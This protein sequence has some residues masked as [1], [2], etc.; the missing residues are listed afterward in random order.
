MFSFYPYQEKGIHRCRVAIAKGIRRLIIHAPTGAGKTVIASGIIQSAQSKNRNVLFV[1]HRKELIDQASKKLDAFQ[2]QHGVIMSNHWRRRYHDPV[3]V[4]SIHTWRSWVKRAET[5]PLPAAFQPYLDMDSVEIDWPSI[6]HVWRQT[7]FVKTF[8]PHLIFIDECHL[9]IAPSYV[10]LVS[11]FPKAVLLGM[12]ATPERAD[13]LP[14][15]EL[16]DGIV[17]ISTPAK[18]IDQGYLV[19]P[20]HYAPV[21]PDLTKVGIKNNDYDPD[22]LAEKF[23]RPD[24]IGDMV[25]EW[26][27]RAKGR[28]TIAFAI[29][30][31]HSRNICEQFESRGIRA[32][33]L[34][35]ESTKHEREHGLAML[36]SGEV[37]VI[38]NVGIFTEGT[39]LPYVSCIILAVAT[40]SL[41]RYL[42]QG[43]RGMRTF[44]DAHGVQKKDCIILDHSGCYHAH[45]PLDADRKWSLD[46]KKKKRKTPAKPKPKVC[47]SCKAIFNGSICPACGWSSEA[48]TFTLTVDATQEL[49]E[50]SPSEI[51]LKL[52]KEEDA[53][54]TIEELLELA[55]QRGYKEA[56]AY[57]RFEARQRKFQAM[58]YGVTQNMPLASGS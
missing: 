49:N 46:G 22:E 25:N 35:G 6:P 51:R 8:R 14:M 5:H 40:R 1:A 17:S 54:K 55:K 45:G 53:A 20:V 57:H 18:L 12:T 24:L 56:W 28:P 26:V 52:K 36:E 19:P 44:T 32:L 48:S 11:S 31:Q 58:R 33:H 50:M 15:R 29:N 38:S 41:A 16:Y 43:G 23:D 13:G 27:K 7:L 30:R 4:A 39:D 2:V 3:Q 9:S 37:Q 21:K 34:D 47:K 10:N 42:Q